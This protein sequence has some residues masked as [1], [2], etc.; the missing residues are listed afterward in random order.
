VVAVSLIAS[1]EVD[2]SQR[3]DVAP[4][5]IPRTLT[6]HTQNV[7]FVS[8]V[9]WCCVVLFEVKVKVKG[10]LELTGIENACAR[11]IRVRMRD[12]CL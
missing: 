10:F 7:A 11:V 5:P 1:C 3:T 4:S 9:R 2:H 8:I 12:T 6:T